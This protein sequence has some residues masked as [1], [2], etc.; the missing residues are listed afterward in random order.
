MHSVS[1][2][3]LL[4]SLFS[5][6]AG[7]SFAASEQGN[8]IVVELFTSEGCSS[9]PPADAILSKLR[10][11]QKVD[12]AQVLILGE[13]VDYWNSLGW[14]DRF[15]SAALTQRQ[16]EYANR[17][18][19][20]SSYTPQMVIDGHVELVGNGERAVRQQL[21]LAARSPKSAQVKLSWASAGKLQ[22]NVDSPTDTSGKVLLAITEDGLSTRVGGGENGGR[23]LNHSG[24]V[25]DLREIGSLKQGKFSETVKTAGNADWKLENLRAVVFVQKPGHGDVL[26]AASLG[27][28]PAAQ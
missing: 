1:K 24:V 18:D 5:A 10:S 11:E 12:G 26:G 4:F 6:S 19:L 28:M 21:N 25:R 9:C 20:N 22:I 23:V 13:H 3:V 2:F 27:Y 8:T 7:S 14:T 15:S 16:A 17:F